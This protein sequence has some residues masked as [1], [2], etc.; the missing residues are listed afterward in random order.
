LEHVEPAVDG[1]SG[2]GRR[3]SLEVDELEELVGAELVRLDAGLVHPSIGAEQV[4]GISA[5]SPGA[6]SAK[7]EGVQEA[8][9]VREREPIGTEQFPERLGAAGVESDLEGR[10]GGHRMV[11]ESGI[12]RSW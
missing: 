3:A 7:P 4:E 8:L 5:G 12:S 6:E 10:G 11:S 9:D 1:R 2:C